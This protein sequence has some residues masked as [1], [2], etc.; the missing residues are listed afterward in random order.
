MRLNGILNRITPLSQDKKS[1]PIIRIPYGKH[2]YGPHPEILGAMPFVLHFSKGSR[3][4]KY[5]SIAHGLKFSFRGKHDYTLVT[6]YPFVAFYEK[7]KQ[8]NRIYKNGKIDESKICPEPIIIEN[9]VWIASNVIIKQGVRV[10]NGAVVAMESLV[11]KDVPPYAI[12]GG[13]PAKIIKYRFSQKQINEL[14]KIAWWDWDDATVKKFL[15]LLLSND[16]DLFIETAKKYKEKKRIAELEIDEKA[17]IMSTVNNYK[18][19]IML[20]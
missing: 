12:V 7:W 20:Q 5:C 16:I 3:I 1:K 10:G 17:I 4:G 8:N 13:N 6:T 11:T 14:L 2:S 15:P 18:D 19:T 9:D